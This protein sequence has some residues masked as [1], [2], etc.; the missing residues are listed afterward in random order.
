MNRFGNSFKPLTW[1][2]ALLLAA[3]V[4]GCGSGSSGNN[5]PGGG[6]GGGGGGTLTLT[7]NAPSITEPAAGTKALTFVLT[8]DS[9]PTA[10]VT[11]SYDTLLTGT[12]TSG[13]DFVA[14]TAGTVTFIAGQTV[15]TASI[16]VNS[17]AAAE[18]NETVLVK[19]S[20]TSLVADVT[21]TGTILKNDT[22][23]VTV[24]LTAGAD[25]PVLTANDDTINTDAAGQLSAADTIAAGDGTDKL[26]ITFTVDTAMTLDDAIF[27]NVSGIDKI[28]IL[29]TGTG[30][31]TITTG[32]MFNA[33]FG[34][35]GV[36]LDTTSSTGP[37]G[38]NTSSFAG[39]TTLA[40]TSTTGAQ[41]ITTGTGVTTVTS[42][43][44]T[45][46][47][48]ITSTAA[49]VATVVVTS[50]D[51]VGNVITTGAGNDSITMVASGVAAATVGNT[52]TGGLGAD[53]IT[54]AADASVDVIVIADGDS[55]ITVATADS[56]TGF[57]AANDSL[58]MGLAGTGA[59]YVEAGVAV[60]DFAAA[61]TAANIALNGTVRYSLQFVTAGLSVTG[62]LFKDTDGD[63]T[64]D[65]VVVL[66][67]IDNTGIDFADIVA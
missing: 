60:A 35:A 38:I 6:G 66:V 45:G 31:Q 40:A 7:A 67:G 57:T 30:A 12:A 36:D 15:A 3:F 56:I 62:Y 64:A 55:G 59:N 48:T 24:V 28:V 29:T 53:T 41:T 37:M 65:Q 32:A 33:A 9:A 63:G 13:V 51:T 10:A 25:A 44:T 16:T 4:A 19:F 26:S 20:G 27:A 42:I 5:P 43:A 52:I 8:L 22:A 21:G 23:G 2:M 1:L 17:D 39:A 11:V 50:G 14:V 58:K 18:A 54:L 61:L 49:V 34:A 46:A 47:R